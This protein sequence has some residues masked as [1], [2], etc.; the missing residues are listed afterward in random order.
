[1][2]VRIAATA[3]GLFAIAVLAAPFLIP[4]D[5]YRPLLVWAIESASGRQIQIDNLKLYLVPTIH[6]RVA[7][8]RM[9]NPAGFP[10]GDALVAK[11]IDLGIAP[12]ALL[13][14][15]LVV[16]YISPND[17]QIRV[18]RNAA[19]R[20]N[21]AAPVPPHDSAPSQP[22]FLT[23]ERIGSVAAT[24]AT[25]TF[26]DA[27]GKDAPGKEQPGKEQP[28]SAFALSGV[29]VKI[30]SIDPL[31]PDWAKGLEIAAD[32]RGAHLTTLL[33]SKP[34]EFQSGELA[35]KGG[36]GR[37]TFA[38]SV[39]S[40]TLSGSV[41]IAR[42]D[43][44]SIAFSLAGPALDLNSLA[45]LVRPDAKD[46]ATRASAH[47][48]LA[49]G[50]IAFG[51]V[52]FAPLE[53]TDL[54]GEL[55]IYASAIHLDASTLSAYGGTVR[56]SAALDGS[57]GAPVSVAAQLHGLNVRSVLSAI[58]LGSAGVT[59]TLDG[60][61]NLTARLTSDPRE[62]LTA[63]GPFAVRNGSFPGLDIKGQLAQSARIA[64]LNVPSGETRF[65]YFGGDL[66]IAQERG[67]SNGLTLLAEGMRATF[68]GSFGFDQTLNY[69]GTAV[70][71]TLAQ[72]ES[73]PSASVLASLQ[74][75]LGSAVHA[76]VR[77]VSVQLPFLLRGT[78]SKPQFSLDGTAQPVFAVSPGQPSQQPVRAP[79]VQDLLKLIPGL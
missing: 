17:V 33:L 14:R 29:N 19:G 54:R 52:S 55:S 77:L 5:R 63:S 1:M 3:V 79:S 41:A 11:S 42:L 65:S 23:L 38:A 67:S 18:L 2:W 37:G 48:L 75:L 15:Q 73:S 58:G 21:F 53:A 70:L 7:N 59:G 27:P 31:A 49:R 13:S 36:S 10:A 68:R 74:Q 61:F 9:K 4:V 35:F 69:S 28:L 43:P 39:G 16:T 12:R 45:T 62:S 25:I 51:R 20:T 32:L 40:L 22:P 76:D 34:V 78:L 71:D 72:G 46:V 24:D 8:F 26:A 60:D 44:M 66:R 50:K 30:A 47:N 64:G 57:P 6:I 56:E